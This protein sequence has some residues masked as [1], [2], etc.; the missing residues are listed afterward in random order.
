MREKGLIMV[1]QVFR[2]SKDSLEF[3]YF[4]LLSPFNFRIDRRKLFT[5]K[6][7]NVFF[8]LSRF[9]RHSEVILM[10][11]DEM[12][13]NEETKEEILLARKAIQE[14]RYMT[15]EELKKELGF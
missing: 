11:E 15:H 7:K 2:F 4:F 9:S 10:D 6:P 13:L 5:S 3:Q 1:L 8:L 14:G 12:E